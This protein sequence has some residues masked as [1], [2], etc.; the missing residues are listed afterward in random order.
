[1]EEIVVA[2]D[3]KHCKAKTEELAGEGVHLS[4]KVGGYFLLGNKSKIL[5]FSTLL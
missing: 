2:R 5:R 1:M 4:D 3:A